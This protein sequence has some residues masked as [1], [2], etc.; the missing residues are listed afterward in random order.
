MWVD[1]PRAGGLLATTMA[2][3]C[4]RADGEAVADGATSVA[5]LSPARVGARLRPP[6]TERLINRWGVS[7]PRP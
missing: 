6:V 1:L 3:L 7:G 4:S 2:S 5:T